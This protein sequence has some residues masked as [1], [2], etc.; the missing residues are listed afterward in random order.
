M[1]A[2]YDSRGSCVG[3]L[4]PRG[5]IVTRSGRVKAIIG[6]GG[7]IHDARGRHLGWWRDGYMRGRDGGVV[8]FRR[9]SRLR[10]IPPTVGPAPLGPTDVLLTPVSPI[11]DAPPLMPAGTFAWSRQTL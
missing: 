10:V 4:G 5:R 2:L 8:A 1:R 11:R 3:Y 9:G 6:R 7:V